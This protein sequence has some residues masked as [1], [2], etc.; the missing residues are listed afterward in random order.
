M[1]SKKKTWNIYV[2][3]SHFNE[4]KHGNTTDS[5]YSFCSDLLSI[6]FC[7][8]VPQLLK[9]TYMHEKSNLDT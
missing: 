4:H 8:E 1:L 9:T 5:R 3:F 6:I 7:A 2:T